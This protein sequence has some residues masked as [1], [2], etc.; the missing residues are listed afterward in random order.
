M[1]CSHCGLCCEKTEMLL[2]S[3][4]VKRLETAGYDRQTF[5]RHDS[6]GFVKMK[7]RRGFCVFYDAEKCR[8]KVYRHRPLGCQIYPVIYSEYDGIVI[9]EL[10]PQKNTINESERRK[11]GKKVIM[12]LRIIDREALIRN[13]SYSGQSRVR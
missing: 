9:D 5:L 1:H 2:S 3:R 8:C 13:E 7:N 11:K 12:L 10:C 6:N 4:D